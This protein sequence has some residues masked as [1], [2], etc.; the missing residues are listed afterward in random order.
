MT[1]PDDAGPS[2]KGVLPRDQRDEAAVASAPS[3]SIEATPGP[4][5]DVAGVRHQVIRADRIFV[6][7]ERELVLLRG[8]CDAA[9]SGRP[10]VVLLAG[11]PGIG[12]TRLAEETVIHA[13]LR[14]A[15]VL[16]GRCRDLKEGTPPY[17]PWVEIIRDYVRTHDPQQLG[18]DLG[19][20]AADIALVVPEVRERLPNL[21]DLP[22]LEGVAARFRLWDGIVNF[23][24]RATARQPLLIVLEDLHWADGD[25]LKLLVH[26]ATGLEHARLLIVGT[27]RDVEVRRGHPLK[28]TLQALVR[29]GTQRT[30]LRGLTATDIASFFTH[31]TGF[32]PEPALVEDVERETA[33]NPL[34]VSE[35]V[36]L[37]EAEGHLDGESAPAS[38]RLSIPHS[39]PEAIS[40]WLDRL[41]EDCEHC[42]E[43]LSLASV[44]GYE[45]TL[46]VLERVTEL[47]PEQ[48]L[49][50]LEEAVRARLILE[51]TTVGRYRFR[52]ALVQETLYAELTAPRRLRLHAGV[53][54]ALEQIHAANL[55]QYYGEL[56]Y[57]FT[58]AA[59][60]GHAAKAVDYSVKAGDGAMSQFAWE[61]AIQ[62]YER[63]L[64]VMDLQAEPNAV[65]RCDVLLAL[66]TAQYRT[67]LDLIDSPEGQHSFL[68][69][70][71]IAKAIGSFERLARA[72][73]E[74]GGVNPSRTPDA[75]QQVRLLEDAL[76]LAPEGDNALKARLMARLA[77]F[78][79]MVPD[80]AHRT[81]TLSD[82]ALAMAQRIGDPSVLAPVLIARYV[83]IW[84]PDNL[85][86]R[87]DLAAEVRN[88]AEVAGDTAHLMFSQFFEL[89]C[90][91]EVG[92]IQTL[93]RANDRMTE[94]ARRSGMPYFWWAETLW[95]LGRAHREGRFADMEASLSTVG[96]SSQALTALYFRALHLFIVRREQGRLA[97]LAQPISDV[98]EMTND[99]SNPFDRHRGQVAHIA[100]LI[101]LIETRQEHEARARFEEFA[102]R[103]FANLAR[104]AYWLATIVLLADVCALLE[105]SKRAATLYDLLLPYADR[106]AAPGS[107]AIYL[108]AV[109]HYLGLLATLLGRWGAAERHFDDALARNARMKAVPHGAWTRAAYARMLLARNSPGD[110]GRAAE[111]LDQA[112]ATAD[113]VGMVRLVAEVAGLR[114]RLA[115][116]GRA[117]GTDALDRFGLSRR[118]LEVVRLLADGRSNPEI[119][120]AL[121]ISVRTVQTH[122]ENI[123]AKLGVHARAE[124]VDVAHR[125]GFL[126]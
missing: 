1:R 112:Q 57:H 106:N 26:V 19:S 42:S 2:P 61:T 21:P 87:L 43:V 31:S 20:G 111:L 60:V 13:H 30:S 98:I 40:D 41:A 99:L 63:A 89:A 116:V 14:G 75:R 8:A 72:A 70:A 49:D 39:V 84:T 11:E 85:E 86:E 101:L 125:H 35:V 76:D 50:A 110:Q 10:G 80:K 64:Y 23:L 32:E 104:D 22:P 88:A 117:S 46:P 47:E 66:G 54:R 45:F 59:P 73:L 103:D 124:A 24:L 102:R 12:K 7:R 28:G 107:S 82:D 3:P 68:Q 126:R 52:H 109:S 92:D 15:Q 16:W 29:V 51:E 119:A 71:A 115:S 123:Y 65:Q 96:G 108:G 18:A 58:R 94:A 93:E 78:C 34:F 79:W 44:V 120:A 55:A 95:Q 38:R 114:E 9:L 67:A 74:Y 48:M 17:W 33:G 77:L 105:D 27:Y 56:A 91:Y 113:R 6:G 62:H 69:A 122:T 53:G 100:Y 36:R 121:F 5:S 4:P 25:S 90:L 37:L 118:E 97:E 81:K 83:P